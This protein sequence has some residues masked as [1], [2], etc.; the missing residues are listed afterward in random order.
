MGENHSD[1]TDHPKTI[2]WLSA[3]DMATFDAQGYLLVRGMFDGDEVA[4]GLDI[5][6]RGLDGGATTIAWHPSFTDREHTIRIRNAISQ[7]PGLAAFLDHPGMVSVLTALLSDSV[8][9]LGTEIFVRSCRDEALEGWHTDGGDYL[10]RIMLAPGSQSLQ[11]KCQVFLTDTSHDDSGNFLLIPG[12]HRRLPERTGTC[13]LDDLNEGLRRGELPEGATTIHAAPGDVLVFPYSLWHAVGPNRRQSRV[14]LIF[15]YGQLWQRPN[16]Y[17]SQPVAL[18][19]R[20]SPRLRRMF[21]DL[22]EN[23]HPLDFYKPTD[24]ADVM[25]GPGPAA[26]G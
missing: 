21:G 14:T 10:Q 17:S 16:D 13:Y 4:E 2:P 22:G 8:Q 15:R 12:S 18:L 7:C 9:I 19:E 23:A 26:R 5:V 3:E 20:F 6:R 24:Q 25:S 1:M 11:I